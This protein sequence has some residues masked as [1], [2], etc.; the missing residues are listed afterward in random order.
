MDQGEPE[1]RPLDWRQAWV[2]PPFEGEGLALLGDHLGLPPLLHRPVFFREHDV[3]GADA[4]PT[5]GIGRG[6]AV[7]GLRRGGW[8]R[9]GQIACVM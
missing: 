4:S 9:L 8:K 2:V 1:P 3:A 5:L 7:A 6:C